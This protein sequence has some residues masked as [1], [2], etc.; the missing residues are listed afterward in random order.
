M[1]EPIYPQT[2]GIMFIPNPEDCHICFSAER[3]MTEP[4]DICMHYNRICKDCKRTLYELDKQHCP[5]CKI[6]WQELY[7][8]EFFTER[9]IQS[10]IEGLSAIYMCLTEEEAIEKC[11][12]T[13]KYQLFEMDYTMIS[14]HFKEG[15]HI[16]QEVYEKMISIMNEDA[17]PIL[18]ALL[19]S[20]DEL[21]DSFIELNGRASLLADDNIEIPIT[22]LNKN[23][24]LYACE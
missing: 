21:C 15:C 11:R 23:L 20:T 9:V 14:Q 12:E 16:P 4:S 17:N 6:C 1:T 2:V 22:I 18:E 19:A 13:I 10:F 8:K 3:P 5:Y 7:R 24:F